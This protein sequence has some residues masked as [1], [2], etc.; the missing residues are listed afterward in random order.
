VRQ[1]RNLRIKDRGGLG[2]LGWENNLIGGE[3]NGGIA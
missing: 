3:Y 1:L 2:F